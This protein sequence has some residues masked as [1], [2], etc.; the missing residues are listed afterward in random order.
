MR[1]VA[2]DNWAYIEQKGNDEVQDLLEQLKNGNLDSNQYV[3]KDG[4]LYHKQ[5]NADGTQNL[6]WFVPKQ[7]RLGILRIFQDEQCHIGPDKTLE[8]IREQF[9]LVLVS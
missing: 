8:S 5:I 3:K 9:W 6:Q 2:H 1:R 4:M 7:S